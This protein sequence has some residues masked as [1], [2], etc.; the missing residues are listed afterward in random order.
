MDE[1]VTGINAK[2]DLL[3]NKLSIKSFVGSLNNSDGRRIDKNNLNVSGSIDFTKFFEPRYAI[4]T[5]GKNIFYRSLNQDIESFADLEI[6][7]VGKDTIDIS[8]TIS[9]NNGAIYKEFAGGAFSPNL[10]DE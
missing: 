9:V 6:Y 4:N 1:P 8:G 10:E 2:A 5:T 3:N 7:I